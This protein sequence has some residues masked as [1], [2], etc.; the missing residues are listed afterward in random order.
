MGAIT[1]IYLLQNTW[2]RV[3]SFFSL[4]CP[5]TCEQSGRS[6]CVNTAVSQADAF[7]L[8]YI[9]AATMSVLSCVLGGLTMKQHH[10]MLARRLSLLLL[11]ISAMQETN[12]HRIYDTILTAAYGP[13]YPP[14]ADVARIHQRRSLTDD[15]GQPAKQMKE[16][17]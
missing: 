4:P 5:G 16:Y 13:L 8:P 14:S 10:T 1:A 6:G 9:T 12:V 7:F 3:I 15:R 17:G 2:A 11:S